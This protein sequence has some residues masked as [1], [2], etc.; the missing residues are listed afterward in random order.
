MEDI[1][2]KVWSLCQDCAITIFNTKPPTID[3]AYSVARL[4]FMTAAHESHF[5]YRRQMGFSPD[6][7]RGAFSLFQV[8][9][10][11]AKDLLTRLFIKPSYLRYRCEDYIQRHQLPLIDIMN[12]KS[13]TILPLL[14]TPE[15]DALGCL[16]ARLKYLA[17]P[18]PIPSTSYEQAVYA[19]RY[20]NTP[21]GKATA[22]DYLKAYEKY[23]R[24][25]Y[26]INT[27]S[28][29]RLQTLQSLKTGDANNETIVPK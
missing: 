26:G 28:I 11:T 4:L 1:I 6:S 29:Q 19:K 14:Q 16:L 2:K 20:Y 5:Q 25:L 21:L 13:T 10:D 7:D 3:Y 18:S 8:E 9:W 27:G 22:M 24:I 15:G 17:Q 23:W 12:V